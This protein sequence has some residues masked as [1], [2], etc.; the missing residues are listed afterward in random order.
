[1]RSAL[2]WRYEG[3]LHEFL[4]C[5]AQ[6]DGG[7]VLPHERSQKRLPGVRLR[8]ENGSQRRNPGSEHYRREAGL[9]ERA[10]AAETDPFLV[11][12][13][14]FYLAQT[15]LDAGDKEMALAA[16]R[17]RAEL[18][19]WDQEVFISLY[20][21]AGIEADLGFDEDAV[22]AS[23]LQAHEAR[24]DRAEALHGAA[25]FCR[26]KERYQQGFDLAKRGVLVKRPDNALIPEDWIYEYGLLDEYAINA[27]ASVHLFAQVAASVKTVRAAD[28]QTALGTAKYDSGGLFP[29]LDFSKPV[30][31]LLISKGA[32][33]IF[34]SQVEYVKVEHGAF[35]PT[36]DFVDLAG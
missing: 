16:Y 33:R 12:R 5:A 15:H 31:S 6:P 27:W 21:S 28:I 1:V 26:L 17:E 13:Y 7:R 4:S 32:P 20:R 18:G 3:V 10:L 19:F 11:A 30:T 8:A 34:T 23:Y 25:R 35:Q 24:K 14:K 9:I 29:T 36:S 22:I 2:P